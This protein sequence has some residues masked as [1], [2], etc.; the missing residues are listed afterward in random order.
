MRVGGN[1]RLGH[2]HAAL[3]LAAG[4]FGVVGVRVRGVVVAEL[5]EP[6][7][8]AALTLKERKRGTRSVSHFR[9]RVEFVE[10]I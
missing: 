3:C 4:V 6:L 10:E 9:E 1:W 7:L 2:A 5:M 8:G